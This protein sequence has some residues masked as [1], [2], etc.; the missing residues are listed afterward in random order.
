MLNLSSFIAIH[1]DIYP[2]SLLSMGGDILLEGM[3]TTPRISKGKFT[4]EVVH[5][6]KFPRR[7][8]P[9]KVKEIA[10]GLERSKGTPS[11]LQAS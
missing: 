11:S 4:G 7:A 6:H 3:P 5:R 10:K 9:V 1:G 8:L 2:Q